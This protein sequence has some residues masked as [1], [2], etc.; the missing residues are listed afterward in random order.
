MANSNQITEVLGI[1]LYDVETMAELLKIS[2]RVAQKHFSKGDI[3]G[4]KI[5]GKWY[6]TE[7]NLIKFI[8][9]E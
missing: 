5:G 9:G 3:K 1:K 4:Q 6:V 7:E 8:Q 2:L